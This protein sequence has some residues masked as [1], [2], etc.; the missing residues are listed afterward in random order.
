A[1]EK[2]QKALFG[3]D[4]DIVIL[5][6]IDQ[7]LNQSLPPMD[8]ILSLLEEKPKHVELV[9]SGSKIP[10]NIIDKSDYVTEM[11][12]HKQ[13]FSNGIENS[14]ADTGA[15]EV[16]TGN[17][18]G[19]TTYCL[20]KGLLVSGTGVPTLILQ[21]IKSPKL[22]GEVKAIQKLPHL[23]IKS[24]GKGFISKNVMHHDPKHKKAARQAWDHCL[25][26]INS[27]EFGL[28]VLDELNIAINYE[29]ISASRIADW[30]LNT[31]PK[32]SVLLSG[33]HAHPD[34]A[35]AC[36]TLIEMKEIKHPYKRGVKAR[37]GIEF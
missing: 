29:L 4:F 33:R 32:L 14:P 17:G 7:L 21:F 6:G 18:K 1:F 8:D 25:R 28:I 9:V 31:P 30:L 5:N 16:I 2:C 22:Y 13:E 12:M 15:I 19:K 11:V 3:G 26:L 27:Q 23:E 10:Q 24:M 34:V 20:G 35:R 37:K 36:T